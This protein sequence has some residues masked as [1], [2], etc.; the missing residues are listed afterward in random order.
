MTITIPE[1]G[2]ADFEIPAKCRECTGT[3]RK[4]WNAADD[5]IRKDDP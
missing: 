4:R 2:I 3:E 1:Y 5:T